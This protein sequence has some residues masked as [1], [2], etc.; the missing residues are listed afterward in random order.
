MEALAS[1]GIQTFVLFG[2]F[3]DTTSSLTGG[4][5]DILINNA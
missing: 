4:R 3:K 1:R 2:E 5:L